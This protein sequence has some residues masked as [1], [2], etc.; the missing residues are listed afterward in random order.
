LAGTTLAAEPDVFERATSLWRRLTH[1][2]APSHAA[3]ALAEE[4]ERRVWVRRH[5]SIETRVTPASGEDETG[6]SARILDVSSG[7][8]KIQLSRSFE[9]GDLLTLELP[10]A[11]GSP[12]VT[13][14]ACVA[15]SRATDEGEWIVGCRFSAEL[16]EADLAAF[17]ASRTKS[18]L[19]DGR[20][21][22]RFTCEVTAVYQVL[23]DDEEF[24]RTAKVLNISAGGFAVIVDHDVRAGALLSAELHAPAGQTVVT[25]LACVVHVTVESDG[26]RTLGCNFIHQL[27]EDDLQALA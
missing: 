25:I 3:A 8:V 21:W 16:S 10:A 17:G 2:P 12:L 23:A 6:L 20:N 11:A 15:H 19:P 26:R 14:L 7:G 4:E 27:S 18:P 1:Q 22:S 24:R 13:V 9:A 5:V